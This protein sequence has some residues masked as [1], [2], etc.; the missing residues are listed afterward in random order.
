M[1]KDQKMVLILGPIPKEGGVTTYI[2]ETVCFL[3]K[4]EF[5]ICIVTFTSLDKSSELLQNLVDRSVKILR[6]PHDAF[7]FY[8][9]I[10]SRNIVIIVSNLYYSTLL[11]FLPFKNKVHVLHGFGKIESG[12]KRFAI[13]NLSN[14]IG[15]YFSSRVIANSYLTSS[16]NRVLGVKYSEV[17]PWGV[18]NIFSQAE[19]DFSKN[20]EIDLLYIGRIHSSKGLIQIAEGISLCQSTYNTKVNFHVVGGL[21]YS[22]D[23]YVSLRKSLAFVDTKFHGYV[24]KQ[25]MLKL[26]TNA[27]L[28]ISLNPDEPFGFSYIEALACG[29]PIIAPRGSG[30]SAFVNDGV[31]LLVDVNGE[32]ISKSIYDGLS[33]QWDRSYISDFSNKMFTWE[34]SGNI[35]LDTVQR[36]DKGK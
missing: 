2:E 6:L 12:I 13:G 20:R 1:Q 7:E 15:D 10:I 16:I 29:T 24:S 11:P 22:S 3:L 36:L 19:I 18:P 28:F 30:I 33:Y 27:K 23:F 25:D 26:Y 5:D 31:A 8:K 34:K 9:L 4:N 35:I 32:S 14:L 21:D 17:V